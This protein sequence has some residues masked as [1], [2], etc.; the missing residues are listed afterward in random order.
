MNTASY[1][2]TYERSTAAVQK[3]WSAD[4]RIF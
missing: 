1:L 4:L 3:N 2:Y